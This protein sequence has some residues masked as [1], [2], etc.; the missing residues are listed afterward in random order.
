MAASDWLPQQNEE[1]DVDNVGNGGLGL[2]VGQ[3]E[4]GQIIIVDFVRDSPAAKSH[5]M[6]KGD[7]LVSIVFSNVS[8]C[9]FPTIFSQND[10]AIS[11]L[12]EAR[13]K[14]R[15][16]IGTAVRIGVARAILLEHIGARQTA[17]TTTITLIR[18]DFS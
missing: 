14:L 9:L 6:I 16:E 1:N 18:G 10:V 13:N 5:A 8:P 7:I 15:G 3:D 17:T 4:K 2:M 12:E 11:T